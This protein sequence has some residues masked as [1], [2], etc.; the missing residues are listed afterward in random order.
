MRWNLR[1]LKADV[2]TEIRRDVTYREIEAA[3]GV[4]KTTIS[5]MMREEVNSADFDVT[6][7][8][9]RYFS[10]LTGKAYALDDII[11]YTPGIEFD[12]ELQAA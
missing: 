5:R 11:T 1:K 3:T 7:R 2:E 8:L 9:L 4:S 10:S 12:S 6:H